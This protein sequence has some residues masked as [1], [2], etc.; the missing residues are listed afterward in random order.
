[1][2]ICRY[3][4]PESTAPGYPFRYSGAVIPLPLIARAF[5][6]LGLVACSACVGVAPHPEVPAAAV[7]YTVTGEIALSR[8]EP[9]VAATQ[10]AAAAAS[11]RDADLLQRAAAVT[12]ECLQ[13]SLSAAVSAHWIDVD[14]TSVEAHRAAGRAA[15]ELQRIAQAAAHYRLVLASSPQGVDAEF[16]LLEAELAVSDNIYGARQLADRL[17]VSF[18]GSGAALRMQAFTALRADDPAAAARDFEAALALPAGADPGATDGSAADGSAAG[19]SEAGSGRSPALERRELQQGLWR[20][21][22]LAGDVSQP[23]LEARALLERD[24]T[25]DNRLDYV[26]LL[27][28]A[29]QTAAA[30]EELSVLAGERD[31]EPMAL[32]LLG[33]IEFQE[34]Q[35]ADAAAHFA[36][37][38]TQ[39]KFVDD[40]MFYLAQIAERHADFARALRLYA[41]VQEGDNAVPALLRAAA[42]LRTHGAAAASDEVLDRLTDEEPQRAPTILAARARML[43]DAGDLP[44]AVALLDAAEQQYPDSVE[45]RYAMAEMVEQGG[46]YADALR[47]L[48]AVAHL[49]PDDP[50]ALNAY[51]YTLADHHRRL[52]LAHKLIQQAYDAAP[53][54]PAILDSLGWV[55]FRQGQVGQALPYLTA[56]YADDR[57][58]DTAAHLGEVLWR[59]GRQSDADRI[60][61]EAAVTDADNRLLKATRQR[62]HA[63]N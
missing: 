41:G 22:I 62:L 25:L 14:P 15:L 26:L 13:P 53:K 11:A 60:W 43:A 9:R 20:A 32:R 54:N 29:Q 45:L 47:V 61:S 37:L 8:H 23:L 42:L 27:L 58:G 56:A 17:A 3:I 59:L 31:S 44:H 5:A 51:G 49:R 24:A 52:R 1:M 4:K 57:G 35:M 18:P 40:S 36:K 28:A 6:G 46:R 19:G 38:V 55:L 2:K 48:K 21:R 33:L 50:A 10:Y 63:A 34:G 7:F 16:A 12:A 30:K 39:G